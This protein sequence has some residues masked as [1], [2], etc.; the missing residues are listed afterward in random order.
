MPVYEYKALNKA[1]KTTSGILDADSPVGARQ[2][3]R[4]SGLF[5]VE[6][7]ETSSKPKTVVSGQASVSTLFQRVKAGEISVMTR[8]LSILLGAGVA[9]VASLDT[10][11]SQI[12]NPAL[13]KILAQIKDAIKT[14]GEHK[15]TLNL[16]EGV[17]VKI[18]I[19]IE[20]DE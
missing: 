17:S 15:I 6:V 8:Q 1:G 10:L 12:T 2:K 19:E 4:G 11:I 5:P 3:L 7:N 9:L 13:K 14:L 20:A 16:A 18:K